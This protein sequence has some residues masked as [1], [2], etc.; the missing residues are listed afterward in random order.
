MNGLSDVTLLVSRCKDHDTYF[1]IGQS[2]YNLMGCDRYHIRC[3]GS[4]VASS[5]GREAATWLLMFLEGGYPG[6]SHGA[7]SMKWTR[8]YVDGR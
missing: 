8:P 1:S 4:W 6:H 5:C 7:G 2:P 3:R